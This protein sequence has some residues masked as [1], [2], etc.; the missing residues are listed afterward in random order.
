VVFVGAVPAP[1]LS[2]S[3]KRQ[4]EC[5]ITEKQKENKIQDTIITSNPGASF[6]FVF[7]VYFRC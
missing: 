3:T 5:E 6:F 4:C 1:A 2:T 7:C